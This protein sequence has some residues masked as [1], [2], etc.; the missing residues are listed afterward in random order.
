MN[1]R[2][3]S[4]TPLRAK[5]GANI[6]KGPI[7]RTGPNSLIISDATLWRKICAV[8][9]P[10][11]RSVWYKGLRFEPDKDIILTH[12]SAKH[13]ETRHKMAAGVRKISTPI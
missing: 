3:K 1:L 11:I 10:Y 8:R 13:Q 7:A 12:R 2:N 9:S 4:A 5:L 6:L